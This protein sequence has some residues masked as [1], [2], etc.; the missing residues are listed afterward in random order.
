MKT[1]HWIFTGIIIIA[2]LVS[3]FVFLAD[4]HSEHWWSH[5]PGFYILWGFLGCVCIIFVSKW[6][7]KLFIQ[8]KED[9]YD[10]V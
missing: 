4:H 8:K 6:L 3:E 10:A 7:G 2:S 5:I 9:Y 1:I